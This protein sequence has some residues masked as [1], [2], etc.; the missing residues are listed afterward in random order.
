[1]ESKILE[2][3]EGRLK[4]AQDRLGLF[5]SNGHHHGTNTGDDHSHDGSSCHDHHHDSGDEFTS[6]T[7]TVNRT[8]SREDI[9]ALLEAFDTGLYGNIIRAKGSLPGQVKDSEFDYV[10]Q[11][12]SIRDLDQKGDHH[13]VI[14]GKDLNSEAL[15]KVF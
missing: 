13:V 10:P 15:L 9:Q 8:F 5:N 11:E 14:I 1:M 6:L 4:T 7:L 12:M 3:R 2:S